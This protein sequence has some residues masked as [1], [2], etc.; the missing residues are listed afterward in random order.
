[1]THAESHMTVSEMQI[2]QHIIQKASKLQVHCLLLKLVC[3]ISCCLKCIVDTRCM[4]Q[5][6]LRWSDGQ[7]CED[8]RDRDHLF[9]VGMI[10]LKARGSVI[11]SSFCNY[12][13]LNVCLLY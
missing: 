5:M 3:L 1:M 11:A 6:V 4:A 13:V 12:N 7:L 10:G 2:R 8:G 9:T